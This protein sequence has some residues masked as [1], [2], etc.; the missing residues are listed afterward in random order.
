MALIGEMR[1]L[2]IGGNTYEIPTS[3]LPIASSSTLGG[4]KVGTNLSIDSSTG[5]LSVTGIPTKINDITTH[6]NFGIGYID[7]SSSDRNI[8]VSNVSFSTYGSS[9]Y[10]SSFLLMF[11]GGVSGST[12]TI[13]GS[14]TFHFY[15][16][17]TNR[18][19]NYQTSVHYTNLQYGKLYIA[20]MSD[21]VLTIKS[22]AETTDIP[23]IPTNI[24]AFTNDAGYITG[25][26]IPVTSVNGN[27]GAITVVEDD[28]KWG[29]V[30]LGGTGANTAANAYVPVKDSIGNTS[31][32]ASW[33]TVTS[34]PTMYCIAKYDG[35]PYLYSTTPSSDD[36]STKVATTAYVDAA[37][38]TISIN[39]QLTNGTKSATININGTDY[40]IYSETNTDTKVTQIPLNGMDSFKGLLFSNLT[41]STQ[42]TDTVYTSDKIIYSDYDQTLFIYNSNKTKSGYYKFDSIALANSTTLYSGL[43][44]TANVTA[45]RTYT[46]PN[47]TGTIAL[48]TDIPTVSITQNLTSGT[49]SATINISGTDY[50]IYSETN[51]DTKVTQIP[52]NGVN[53][54]RGLLFAFSTGSTQTTNTVYTSNKIQYNDSA[55]T[56]SI[57][58][59]SKTKYGYFKYDSLSLATNS[60]RGTL[61]VDGITASRT[62]TLPNASGTIALTSDI[63]SIPTG[64]TAGQVL[65]K[66][67][68]TNYDVEWGAVDAL[69]SITSSDNNK[70]LMV[71]NGAWAAASLPTYNGG[72]S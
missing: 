42:T 40:D 3:E 17:N 14:G 47:A 53:S 60:Y 59:S 1:Y 45:N 66:T 31:G 50:D 21:N 64:G 63:H 61:R 37:I 39:Q 57:Y 16:I 46:L 4:I 34:T 15:D 20:Y 70:V 49:K 22:I 5:V 55:P 62:Y 19:L 65:K 58:D 38:P 11:Q 56:L 8:F 52:L 26:D 72:V 28:H 71:V 32:T 25:S 36:N 41:G 9:D 69:P 48:T 13:P 2:Q 10:S 68:S 30:T 29:G 24:S 18:L 44:K 12:V 43:L 6:N 33:A 35:G 51:T 67:S 27:T 54:N 23:T 7:C